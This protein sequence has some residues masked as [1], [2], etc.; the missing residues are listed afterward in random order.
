MEVYK[1]YEY[2][3]DGKTVLIKRKYNIKGINSIKQN[4]L[5]EYFKNNADDIRS[6]KKI[7]EVLNDYNNTHK[8]K[9]SYSM[10]YNKYKSLFGMRKNNIQSKE[11]DEICEEDDEK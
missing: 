7:R 11:N 9:I 2:V 3:K 10:L 5:N 4:E 8:N 6:N 1:E